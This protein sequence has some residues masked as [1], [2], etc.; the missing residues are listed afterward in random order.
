MSLQNL[1]QTKKIFA[2]K[3]ISWQKTHG[4]H[5]LP[6]QVSDPYKVWLSEIMLQ[7]TQVSTVLNYY[8]RFLECF[9]TVQALAEAPLDDVL[10]LW[11]GL[12]YYSRA[13][14]LHLAA[15]QIVADFGGQFPSQRI[16]LEKL[17]GVG[18]TTAAAISAFSFQQKETILDGNVKRVLCR[19]LAQDGAPED[20]SFQEALW[21]H[22]EEML[23]ESSQDMPAYTQGLMDL[24]ATVCKRSKPTCDICPMNTIC[25]AYKLNLTSI[26]PRK[27]QATKVKDVE[28]FWLIILFTDG[29]LYIEQRSD[30]NIW[31]HLFCCPSFDSFTDA[32]TWLN[33][34]QLDITDFTEEAS[35]PH[36]L[37][38]RRLTIT[39]F[40]YIGLDT[41]HPLHAQSKSIHDIQKL[42]I[43]KPFSQYLESLI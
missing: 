26:L 18:R 13:K 21:K 2:N 25:E 20:K 36:V 23:P 31:K 40:K 10:A 30:L 38:H 4:R 15:K 3:L 27:K 34:H 6:W 33:Q 17:K 43:P 5:N 29:N 9:P 32:Q 42:G 39:P 7:Q 8:P 22:A 12:G 37:T 41:S 14:N 19:V 24:G 16:E 35:F 1:S 11:A 28:L